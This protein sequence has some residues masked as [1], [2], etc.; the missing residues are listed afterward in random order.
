MD[1][2]FLLSSIALGLSAVVALV[3]MLGI[4]LATD[5]HTLLQLA[6][7]ALFCFVLAALPA[8]VVLLV[9]QWWAAAMLVGTGFLLALALLNWRLLSSRPA[10]FQPAWADAEPPGA[11]NGAH[12]P[13]EAELV[14]RAAAVLEAYL[15]HAGPAGADARLSAAARAAGGDADEAASAGP[16]S[17]QEA[18]AVLGL[19]EGADAKAIREAHRRLLQLMHPDRG[20]SNYLAAKIN[21]AKETLLAG[22]PRP[23]SRTAGAKSADPA[24]RKG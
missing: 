1:T 11:T 16:M 22:R 4:S 3:R 2:A 18:H 7:W 24:A 23:R 6:Q 15:E 13:D 20:G 14:A 17:R 5:R 8:I 19:D 10:T 21:Q 9:L 12:G